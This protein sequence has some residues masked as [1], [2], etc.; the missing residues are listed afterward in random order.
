[1]TTAPDKSNPKARDLLRRSGRLI[2][3]LALFALAGALGALAGANAVA[4]RHTAAA[5]DALRARNAE[6]AHEALRRALRAFPDEP[7]ALGLLGRQRL[8]RGDREGAVEPL[9]R[10][11]EVSP[12]P[13]DPLRLL[14][15]ILVALPAYGPKALPLFEWS[16]LLAPPPPS[17]APHVWFRLGE[18]ARDS[19][20][21]A[22]AAWA[23]RHAEAAGFKRPELGVMLDEVYGQ[24]GLTP[25][26][27]GR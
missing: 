14:G 27:D 19:R 21:P 2:V 20:E 23:L 16:L 1:M 6:A 18:A 7:V 22:T 17:E 12:R 5:R 26:E 15:S 4:R 3:A 8:L 13:A 10:A 11:A 24:L 25:Q 9:R